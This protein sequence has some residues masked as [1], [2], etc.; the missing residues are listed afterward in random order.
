MITAKKRQEFRIKLLKRARRVEMIKVEH[1]NDE[2]DYRN[3]STISTLLTMC[4]FNP[5]YGK[6]SQRHVKLLKRNSFVEVCIYIAIAEAYRVMCISIA[7]TA[8]IG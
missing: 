3:V 1:L 5:F 8:H 2:V 4:I 6:S 7:I